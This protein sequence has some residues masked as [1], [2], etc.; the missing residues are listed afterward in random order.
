MGLPLLDA[1][2]ATTPGGIYA[3][4]AYAHDAHAGAVV[5]VVQVVRVVVMLVVGA[6]IP[7]LLGRWA[8]R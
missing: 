8:R 4:L 3:V 6:Y 2:L 1:Y 7:V 5:T